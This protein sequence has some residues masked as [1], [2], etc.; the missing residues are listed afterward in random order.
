MSLIRRSGGVRAVSRWLFDGGQE[1]M[2]GVE[3]GRR[4]G[5][6]SPSGGG[7]QSVPL[8]QCDGTPWLSRE[9]NRASAVLG[10]EVTG[11]GDW[12]SLT[13]TWPIRGRAVV[14]QQNA[15]AAMG[16]WEVG[17]VKVVYVGVVR[18]EPSAARVREK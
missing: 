18:W 10:L 1:W 8:Q 9:T 13:F 4:E 15:G 12:R 3:S 17:M 7:R 16:L 14:I 6:N 2:L 11:V 5:D